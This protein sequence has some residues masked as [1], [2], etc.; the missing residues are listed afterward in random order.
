VATRWGK[1]VY[2]WLLQRGWLPGPPLPD[3]VHG[4]RAVIDPHTKQQ[5]DVY[6]AA[7]VQEERTGEYPDVPKTEIV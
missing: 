5:I 1:H 6:A 2:N 4:D 3:G 7:K